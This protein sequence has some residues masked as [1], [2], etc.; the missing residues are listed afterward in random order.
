M[1]HFVDA[2]LFSFSIFRN[3]H[4]PFLNFPLSVKI[5]N[6]GR[7]TDLETLVHFRSV[8]AM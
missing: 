4:I 2:S 6:N 7:Y 1:L 8:R 3:V 5:K